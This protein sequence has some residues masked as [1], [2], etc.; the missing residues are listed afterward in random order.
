[1]AG[2][3]NSE[4]KPERSRVLAPLCGEITCNDSEWR[5]PAVNTKHWLNLCQCGAKIERV[6]DFGEFAFVKCRKC[7]RTT[8]NCASG[9]EAEKKWNALNPPGTYG[10]QPSRV[11]V[12]GEKL[13]EW[14][15]REMR[16]EC[17]IHAMEWG[18]VNGEWV[19]SMWWPR[20]QQKELIEL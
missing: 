14:R 3:L 9:D 2:V 19:I 13:N 1:M 4:G 5:R 11:T 15:A 20:E 8:G 12:N 17:I 16:G 18:K 7:G 10:E 6:Q